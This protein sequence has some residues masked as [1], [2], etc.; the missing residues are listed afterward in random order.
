MKKHVELKLYNHFLRGYHHFTNSEHCVVMLHGYTGNQSEQ[1]KLIKISEALEQHNI[2]SLRMSYF[3]HGE[4][5]LYFKDLTF[6]FLLEQAQT[7]IDY[8]KKHHQSIY[9]LG[10]SMG[11]FLS[12][13]LLENDIKKLILIAPAFKMKELVTRDYSHFPKLDNGSIDI[14]GRE[15]TQAFMESFLKSDPFK[16]AKTYQNPILS[17][18]GGNDIVVPKKYIYQ[19][20]ESFQNVS[21][22]EIEKAGHG[23]NTLSNHEEIIKNI[24]DFLHKTNA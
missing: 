20:L 22:V 15:Q 1:R 13:H 4:S 11:V 18:I 8:A 3:G 12:L 2:D 24:L 7:I 16:Y 10:Y 14:G 5:D 17:I 6:D 21:T 9:L 23:F 19:G